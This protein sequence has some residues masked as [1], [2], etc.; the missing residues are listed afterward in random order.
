MQLNQVL[1]RPRTANFQG[2]KRME[3][4]DGFTAFSSVNK[5]MFQH[6]CAFRVKMEKDIKQKNTRVNLK[7]V[8]CS[9]RTASIKCNQSEET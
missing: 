5:V 7:Q 6:Y 8:Y 2:T 3:H 9:A 1:L 4:T